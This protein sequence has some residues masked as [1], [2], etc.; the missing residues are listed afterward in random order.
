[1]KDQFSHVYEQY[2]DAFVRFAT[3]YTHDQVVAEDLVVD[4]MMYYW[5]NR[6]RLPADTNVPGY[7]LTALKHKCINY[8][9]HVQICE[10]VHASIK[11]LQE[12]DIETRVSSLHACEPHELYNKEIT[13][14]VNDTL[15]RLPAKSRLIFQMSRINNQTNKQIAV[16]MHVSVKTVEFHVTKVLKELRYA[17]RDYLAVFLGLFIIELL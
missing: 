8:L 4:S 15:N 9:E 7:I 5:E 10:N 13:E 2:Y 12:W 14:I 1:M 3:S 16:H 11:E 6:N 17:L